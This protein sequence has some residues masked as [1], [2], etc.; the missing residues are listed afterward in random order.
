MS[1]QKE[2]LNLPHLGLE[3]IVVHV[4]AGCCLVAWIELELGACSSKVHLRQYWP[5]PVD[6][7]SS[8]R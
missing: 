4:T 6:R 7:G 1:L 3:L 8:T 2:T 5:Y